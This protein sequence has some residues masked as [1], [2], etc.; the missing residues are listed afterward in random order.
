[1]SATNSSTIRLK[2]SAMSRDDHESPDCE[3]K[4]YIYT[5]ICV[6]IPRSHPTPYSASA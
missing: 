5:Y 3:L 2:W 1:M 4:T 6:N